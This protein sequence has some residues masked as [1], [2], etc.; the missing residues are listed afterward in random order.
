MQNTWY[1]FIS[2]YSTHG[3]CFCLYK[4]SAYGC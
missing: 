3:L 2:T 1:D 4:G